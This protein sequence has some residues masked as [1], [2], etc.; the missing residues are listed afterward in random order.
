[1]KISIFRKATALFLTLVMLMTCVS[2]WSEPETSTVN[3]DATTENQEV[4]VDAIKVIEVTPE[5]DRTLGLDIVTDGHDADVDVEKGIVVQGE[6]NPGKTTYGTIGVL[7]DA[8]GDGSGV[9]L[10]IG[11]EGLTVGDSH[12]AIGMSISLNAQQD[13]S[14]EITVDGPVTV[15]VPEDTGM[16]GN[17]TGLSI[18]LGGAADTDVEVEIAGDLT[19]NGNTD[20]RGISF[21]TALIPDTGNTANVHVEGDLTARTQETG[22]VY[23]SAQAIQAE[24]ICGEETITV[25]GS[26]NAEGVSKAEVIIAKN[27]HGQL[28][29]V[30]LGWF[31]QYTKFTDIDKQVSEP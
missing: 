29:K 17:A 21:G 19:V 1:M 12:N 28:D 20:A 13:N 11:E 15:S 24:G 2:A 9:D 18:D 26:I 27:R 7:V 10:E 16:N 25:D 14:A 31:G 3:V 4:T 6:N 22:A 23:D 8:L 5:Y 30:E